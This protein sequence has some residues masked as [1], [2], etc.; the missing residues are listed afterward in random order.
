MAAIRKR[1]TAG[2]D[3]EKTTRQT[4]DFYDAQGK[5]RRKDFATKREA[6]AFRIE[7]EDQ[8]RKGTFRPDADK[9]TV[10]EAADLFLKHCRARMERG[11]R[12]TRRNFQTYEGYVRNYIC[13]DPDWHAKKHA[14]PHHQFKF[15]DK[16]IGH[17]TLWQLTTGTVTKFRDDLR[18]FGV[19][20]PTTRKI[21]T[22]LKVML[23]F[24]IGQDLTAVNAAEKVEVIG[25]RGEGAEQVTPPDKEV[26]RQLIALADED[27][28]VKLIFAAASGVRAGELHALRWKHVSFSRREV[29]IET[30][31]DPYGTEDV[32]KTLAGIRT[33]P[34]GENVLLALKQWKLRSRFREQGD[35]VFPNTLGSYLNHDDMVKRKFYP[36]FERLTAKW[37][38]ERCNE[39]L[40]LFNWHALRHFAISCWIDAG[41]PP[42]TVQ[43]FAG[44]SSLQVTMDRYGHLFRSDSH[45]RAMDAIASEIY[46]PSAPKAPQSLNPATKIR[47]T[48]G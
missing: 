17:K 43:T 25:K 7:M 26:M 5:R 19:S 18:E 11:E 20:V 38:E 16:G 28:Q 35:L 12:M 32:P 46:A 39:P 8:K 27:F 31:V 44:H 22:M 14:K 9:V 41:L 1:I 48:L 21:I 40:E 6:D 10:K 2:K 42:K 29:K 30:R 3:G 13:P 23:D 47:A 15:F 37:K 33:I 45:S 34:L 24:A 4:V 36:L